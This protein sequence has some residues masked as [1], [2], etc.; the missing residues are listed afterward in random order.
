MSDNG[1]I[2]FN[3]DGTSTAPLTSEEIVREKLLTL[4]QT[5]KGERPNEPTFGVD[6]E[7][8]IMWPNNDGLSEVALAEVR[9]AVAEWLPYVTI[10][11]VTVESNVRTGLKKI[12]I[13]YAITGDLTGL[14]EFNI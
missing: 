12:S 3:S 10:T 7:R 13:Y 8:L 11:Q 14:V 2:T 5:R 6:V 1:I 4:L 9:N